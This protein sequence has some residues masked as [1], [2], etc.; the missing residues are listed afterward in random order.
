MKKERKGFI[1]D[2][3]RTINDLPCTIVVGDLVE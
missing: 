3:L 1:K 2:F